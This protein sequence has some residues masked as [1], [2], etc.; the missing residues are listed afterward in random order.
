ML[1]MLVIQ[2]KVIHYLWVKN[3]Y[4]QCSLFVSQGVM[5]REGTS[6]R[7]H[8]APEAEG[9]ASKKTR[10]A[11]TPSLSSSASQKSALIP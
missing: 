8:D 9:T 11:A 6:K 2:W 1:W 10:F 7:P 5:L 4:I 3:L